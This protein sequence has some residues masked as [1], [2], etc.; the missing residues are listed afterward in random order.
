[1]TGLRLAEQE[2]PLGATTTD[3]AAANAEDAQ[4]GVRGVLGTGG[5]GASGF[6]SQGVPSSGRWSFSQA[7][8]GLLGLTGGGS[9]AGGARL[10][11]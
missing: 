3:P 2:W 8:G 11:L 7:V 10:L 1:M 5:E 9:V 4:S 6:S